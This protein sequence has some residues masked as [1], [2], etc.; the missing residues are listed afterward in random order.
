MRP[1]AFR[2]APV[3]VE[4]VAVLL[5]ALGLGRALGGVAARSPVGARRG[6]R[7]SAS[8]I[9]RRDHAASRA[10][11]PRRRP[12]RQLRGAA[13][14]RAELRRSSGR[15]MPR[16]SRR[17]PISTIGRR[18]VPLRRS[19]LRRPAGARRR[20]RPLLSSAVPSIL[21]GLVDPRARLCPP[22]GLGSHEGSVQIRQR[23]WLSAGALLLG[24][25]LAAQQAGAHAV[26]VTMD[27]A[28]N[29]RLDEAPREAVIRF[30]ERVE[31]RPSTLEVLDARGQR[32]DRAGRP[33]RAR[34][35]V[36]VSRDALA[37][38]ARRLH[39]R[40]ARSV[41]RRRSRDPRR[42]RVQRRRR[43]RGRAGNPAHG[44]ERSGV[45]AARPLDGRARAAR[46][47]SVPSSRAR[48]SASE[49]SRGSTGN[50]DPGGNGRGSRGDAGS[51][52]A[53]AP[54]RRPAPA[55]GD[56]RGAPDGSARPR[57]ARP[58]GAPPGSRRRRP[59]RREAGRWLRTGLAAAVVMT[60]GFVSHG[61]AA[62]EGRWLDSRPRGA[63]PPGHG[64]VGRRPDRL[65]HRLLAHAVAKRA[66]P[67]DRAPRARDPHVL[68]AGRAGG[69]LPRGERL[70]SW[71][72][73]TS[74]GWGELLGTAY[75]RWLAAKLGVFLVMLGA[76]RLAPG[77]D[78]ARAGARDPAQRDDDRVAVA[79][80]AEHPGR[81]RARCR[82]AR[83]GRHPRRHGAAGPVAVG[84][85]GAVGRV[86]SRASL[87]GGA[88]AGR[89]HSPPTGPERDSSRRDRP[90]GPPA[91]GRDGRH[92]PDHA[93]RRERRRG[94]LPARPRGAGRV[95]RPGGRARSRRALERAPRRPAVGRVRRQRPVR[96]G[97]RRGA[98]G[99][100]ARRSGGA[101]APPDAARPSSRCGAVLATAVITL[102]LYLR[103]RRRLRTVRR[104]LADTPHPPAAAPAPR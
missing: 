35:S 19:P 22:P 32:V 14:G 86:S 28:P 68:R 47:S 48:C 23:R 103:S 85:P 50:G 43:G 83:V 70:L 18:T 34:R 58:R 60:G 88:R 15:S 54:A 74:T 66:D 37:A 42:P 29:A 27:P 8:R 62:S 56:A 38:H 21:L 7:R 55:D 51:R 80:P 12:G 76:R 17:P 102:A 5:V 97:R 33:G 53:G 69:R 59:C 71:R 4:S 63:P 90:G 6:H 36:A 75:G 46:S 49:R 61:A 89:D 40:L 16:R 52:P 98:R 91:R 57:V 78:R 13:D 94:H 84:R 31:P 77:A 95:R 20:R 87:R 93:R 10:S 79:I 101:G 24:A 64:V 11:Q 3:A 100:R 41:R 99:A 73:F 72:G 67:R 82:R 65:R 2:S 1:P 81:G 45:E 39:G 9:R 30:S 92:D 96:A 104:L 44:A 26:P 25:A